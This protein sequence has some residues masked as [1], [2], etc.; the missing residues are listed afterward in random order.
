MTWE[1]VPDDIKKSKTLS[2]FKDNIKNW[3]PSGCKCRLCKDYVQGV[4]YVNIS[5][6]R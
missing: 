3:K 2:T 1:M 6:E 5:Q 4:G